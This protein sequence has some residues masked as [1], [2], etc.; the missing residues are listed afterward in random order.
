MNNAGFILSGIIGIIGLATL[1]STRIIQL[2]MPII[3]RAAFQAAMK[4]SYNPDDYFIDFTRLQLLSA[5]LI[6]TALILC[7]KLYIQ[8]KRRQED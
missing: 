5:V 4:G 6:V 7:V 3:G 8:E 2:V 1:I